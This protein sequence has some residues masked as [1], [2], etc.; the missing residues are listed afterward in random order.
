MTDLVPTE[1]GQLLEHARKHTDGKG[2]SGREAAR[3][4]GF[5]EGRWR[6]LLRDGRGPAVTVVAA[7]LAVDADPAAALNAAGLPSDP[8]TVQSLIQDATAA[9]D[10]PTRPAPGAS[11]ADEIERIRQ[12]PLPA[13]ERLRVAQGVIALFEDMAREDREGREA[14]PVE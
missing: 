8:D 5:S 13:R 1:L 12:L 3:R 9:R 7:A 4:A 11:L 6:G 14:E 10:R 2:I